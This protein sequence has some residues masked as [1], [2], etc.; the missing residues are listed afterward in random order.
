MKKHEVLGVPIVDER[1]SLLQNIVDKLESY[2]YIGDDGSLEKNIA[3]C[4]LKEQARLQL[5]QPQFILTFAKYPKIGFLKNGLIDSVL[6]LWQLFPLWTKM[7]IK[8]HV[9]RISK[10]VNFLDSFERRI[11]TKIKAKNT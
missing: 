5:K 10:S 9:L 3:F 4:E 11:I 7:V 8:Y 2:N 1:Y 6:P